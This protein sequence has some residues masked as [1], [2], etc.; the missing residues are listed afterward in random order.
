MGEPATPPK[1]GVEL[2]PS[3]AAEYHD[4]WSASAWVFL[5]EGRGLS[6]TPFAGQL[7][8][9]QAGIRVVRVLDRRAGIGAVARLATPLR[10]RGAEFSVGAEWRLRKAPIRFVIEERIGIDGIKSGPGV[11]VIVG[12][13][14]LFG[15]NIRLDYYGQAGALHRDR[16]EPYADGAVRVAHHLTRDGG[17]DIGLG[18]WGAAQR[19]VERVDLG[20][21]LGLILPVDRQRFRIT[22]DWR[23]RIFG[24]ALPGSGAVVTLG[25]DL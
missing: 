10:G 23:Q 16:F 13:T 2:T 24:N 6:A 18:A 20:P 19:G 4:D 25:A 22:V 5:R 11:G 21:S 3:P 14:R 9:A 1:V 15:G 12:D 7:G 17:L 8:G